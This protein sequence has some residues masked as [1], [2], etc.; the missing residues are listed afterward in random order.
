MSCSQWI[1]LHNAYLFLVLTNCRDSHPPP[2]L[3][4][5]GR[6]FDYKSI[7]WPWGLINEWLFLHRPAGYFVVSRVNHTFLS[8]LTL[9]L[10]VD[11]LPVLC[12]LLC[13]FWTVLNDSSVLGF[14]WGAGSSVYG[15][16][17]RYPF[18]QLTDLLVP[19]F[20]S[21]TWWIMIEQSDLGNFNF[22]GQRSSFGQVTSPVDCRVSNWKPPVTLVL[23]VYH[24]KQH[25]LFQLGGCWV[26]LTKMWGYFF[27]YYK[28]LWN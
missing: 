9:T 6:V 2:H 13:V 27:V 10:F 1:L 5:V 8:I 28:Y 11:G 23:Y 7:Y 18:D 16:Q 12:N 26:Y 24:R 14:G 4:W 19:V 21:R 25:F 15:F 17:I 22:L 3:P 20:K